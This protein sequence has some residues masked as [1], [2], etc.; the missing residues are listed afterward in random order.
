MKHL[1]SALVAIL[2]LGSTAHAAPPPEGFADLAEKLTPAVVNI[3]TIPQIAKEDVQGKQPQPQEPF[4]GFPPGSP[5]EEFNEM[6]K[7]FGPP[8]GE[9]RGTTSLGSGFIIDPDGYI[10]TNN[11]VIADAEEITVSLDDNK[12]Y[13]AKII[14]KDLKTDLAVLKIEAG[15][16]LAFVHFGDSDKMRVGDWILAVGNPYGLGGTVTAGIISARARDINAGL[17]DDFLQTDAAINRGNSGGPMFNMNGE[18]V[19]INTAIYSPTGGSIGIGFAVPAALAQPVIEKLKTGQ[20]IERGW[21]GVKIQ[22]VTDEIAESLSMKK[23]QGALVVGVTP[24]GPAEKSKLQSGDVIVRF[25]GQEIDTMRKLPRIVADTAIGTKTEIEVWRNGAIKKFDVTVGKLDEN[26]EKKIMDSKMD[27]SKPAPV[28]GDDWLG[29]R[30][31]PLTD[32]LRAEYGIPDTAKGMLILEVKP[33]SQAEKKA[34]EAG[35]VIVEANQKPVRN[36]GDLK[37][38]LN[39]AKEQKRKSILLYINKDGETLFSALPLE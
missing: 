18:V 10:V 2:L 19:G 5:F 4:Q 38:A 7:Q 27:D 28:K 8:H 3:S 6:F 32:D 17:F 25:R 37:S 30:V 24:G 11:H 1:I 15:R 21:L 22:T 9:E 23:T 26:E 34:I 29:M 13:K 12:Q 36:I 16:K 35:D 33:G 39:Y 14:G 31:A 20:K